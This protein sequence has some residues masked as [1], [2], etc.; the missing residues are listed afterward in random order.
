[1]KIDSKKIWVV[2]S[3]PM[4]QAYCKVLLA[5]GVR[6]EVVGRGEISARRLENEIGHKVHLGGVDKALASLKAPEFAIVA[7]G[8]EA[9]EEATLSLLRGGTKSIL[10]EKPGGLDIAALGR[11]HAAM[12]TESA[13]VFIAYNRRFYASVVKLREL[14]AE[15]GGIKSLQYEFTE[16][17]HVVRKLQTATE[18]K[19]RWFIANSSHVVDLAFHLGGRPRDWSAWHEGSLDWHPASSR[20]CGAGITDRNVLFNYSADWG[21]PGRWGLQVTTA[22]RRFILR[23]LEEIKFFSGETYEEECLTIDRSLDLEYKP[24]IFLQTQAFLMADENF[25]C[26]AQEQLSNMKTYQRMAGY[27]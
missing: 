17:S 18:I 14:I 22:K 21:A 12:E 11:I 25:L 1:M 19:E 15:E 9:L 23:P 20:F 24:G 26:S 10:T 4:A 3:G 8:V 16:R 27:P 13:K 5:L 6:F 2:G 7:T